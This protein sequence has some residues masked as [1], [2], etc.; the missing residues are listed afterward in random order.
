MTYFQR[1]ERFANRLHED[2]AK[3]HAES[4]KTAKVAG[5]IGTIVTVPVGTLAGSAVGGLDRV[6]AGFDTKSVGKVVN[7]GTPGDAGYHQTIEMEAS[8]FVN[9]M[10]ALAVPAGLGA[11]AAF[12]YNAYSLAMTAAGPGGAGWWSIP[13]AAMVGAVGAGIALTGWRLARGMFA[14]GKL[15]F[16]A[17]VGTASLAAH[18]LE[19]CFKADLPRAATLAGDGNRNS[20]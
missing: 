18:K 20:T 17:G 8:S 2:G 5:R 6:I 3:A 4:G 10:R 16:K 7:H 19:T 12:T 11:A 15:G 13:G 1:L 9:T 14:G